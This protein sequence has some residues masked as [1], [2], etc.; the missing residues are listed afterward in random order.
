M[1]KLK[2]FLTAT[3]FSL[4]LAAVAGTKANAQIVERGYT[5]DL[6]LGTCSVDSGVDCKGGNVLCKNDSDQLYRLSPFTSCIF[7]LY[8]N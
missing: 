8:Q 5:L 6:A 4:A 1:N 2:Y 3:T 7:E